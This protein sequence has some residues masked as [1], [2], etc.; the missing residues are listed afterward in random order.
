MGK[1]GYFSVYFSMES[2]RMVILEPRVIFF[3]EKNN[4]LLYHVF[5]AF[6]AINNNVFFLE[7]FKCPFTYW[8]N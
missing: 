3:L 5:M 1:S 6:Y 4:S 8:F 7:I 2:L